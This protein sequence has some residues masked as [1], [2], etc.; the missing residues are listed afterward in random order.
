MFYLCE[1]RFIAFKISIPVFSFTPCLLAEGAAERAGWLR[2]LAGGG[3]AALGME[4]PGAVRA[5]AGRP[6]AW[7]DQLNLP[8]LVQVANMQ[9]QAQ[10]RNRG[11]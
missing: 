10:A 7:R 2:T 1:I 8:A 3:A 4:R 9:A 11:Q 6:L 5:L